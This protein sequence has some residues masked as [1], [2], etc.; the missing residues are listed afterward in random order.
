M[1]HPEFTEY[2]MFDET[3]RDAMRRETELFFDSIVREDRNVL[4]LLNADY[5]FVN[6]RLARHYGIAGVNGEAFRASRCRRIAAG[7]SDRR[8]SSRSP[9]SPTAPRRCCAASG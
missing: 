7:C 9:R 4:D 1:L 2:A 8:A 5:S 6:G 3:L